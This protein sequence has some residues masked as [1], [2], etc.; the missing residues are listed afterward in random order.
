MNNAEEWILLCGIEIC[1]L[2]QHAFD[3]RAVITRPQNYFARAE[4]ECL[5]L[6]GRVGK[7]P[8]SKRLG[9]GNE[10]FIHAGWRTCDK[11]DRL[12]GTAERKRSAHSVVGPGHAGDLSVCRID[13]KQMRSS[14]L[15]C[16]KIN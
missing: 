3:R 1:R 10:N 5:R 7:L 6:G 13:A 16:G 8:R 15:R 14:L 12:A 9:S 4:R 11:S 2:N